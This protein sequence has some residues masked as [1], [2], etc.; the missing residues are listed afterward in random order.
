MGGHTERLRQ[1]FTSFTLQELCNLSN[2]FLLNDTVFYPIQNK[3]I[4]YQQQ[5]LGSVSFDFIYWRL[6]YYLRLQIELI[7]QLTMVLQIEL[8]LQL[9]MVF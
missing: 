1:L 9:M 2:N 4:D 5:S 8:I 3:I 6:L 7:L